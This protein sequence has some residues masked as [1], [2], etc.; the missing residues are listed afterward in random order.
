MGFGKVFHP[1]T[2]QPPQPKQDEHQ[3]SDNSSSDS[4][5]S[6][7]DE[8]QEVADEEELEEEEGESFCKVCHREVKDSQQGLLCDQCSLWS[9]R[10]CLKVTKKVYK[11]MMKSDD[12]RWVCPTCPPVPEDPQ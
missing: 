3:D 6:E 7:E 2:V 4:D 11:E 8:E 1:C 9:H 12:L 5:G 10:N